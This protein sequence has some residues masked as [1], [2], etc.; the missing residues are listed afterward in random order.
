[1]VFSITRRQSVT[2]VPNETS[3]LAINR[4]HKHEE[5]AAVRPLNPLKLLQAARHRYLRWHRRIRKTGFPVGD[6][7]FADI[8]VAT[9]VQRDAV[10]RQEFSGLDAGAVLAAKPRD[11]FS[12][13]VHDAE[14]RP[15][16]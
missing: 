15:E 12:L 5:A 4:R 13:S 16:I 1:M 7:D 14:A 10:R 11:A 3:L 6:A 9:R 8:D 2:F